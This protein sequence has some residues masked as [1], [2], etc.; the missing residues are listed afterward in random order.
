MISDSGEGRAYITVLD[1][2]GY[3]PLARAVS[4][5]L[6]SR[7]RS[8]IIKSASVSADSWA[9]LSHG[10]SEKLGQLGVRQAS[11]IGMGAGA[12]L[13]QNLALN[14]PRAVRSMAVIDSATR[15][16]PSF[17]QRFTDAL[18]SRLPFGLPLRLG[19]RGFNVSSYVHRFRCPLLIVSTNRAS[20]FIR[21][22]LQQLARLAPTAWQVDIST[23]DGDGQG[24]ALAQTILA[25]QETPV[26]CPQKNAGGR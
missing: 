6:A 16:H 9:I 5:Q 21:N 12:T 4:E 14:E 3:L 23:M 18:E 24:A 8:I 2:D 26:K 11:F 20:T 15:P 17:W 19:S 22:E 10:L 1:D 7:A 25:F 13:A